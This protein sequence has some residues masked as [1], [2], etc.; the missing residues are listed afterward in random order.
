[1]QYGEHASQ[2]MQQM[3]NDPKNSEYSEML[4][5]LLEDGIWTRTQGKLRL[6]PRA[7][8][9]CSAGADGIFLNLRQGHREGHEKVT[10]AWAASESK[11]R[12]PISTAIP[13]R[14]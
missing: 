2:A 7:I 5:K 6:T 1:M 12:S 10:P 8:A 11:A 3:M 9:A 14:T 13:Q 4:E